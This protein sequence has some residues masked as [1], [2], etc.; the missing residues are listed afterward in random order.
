MCGCIWQMQ[1]SLSVVPMRNDRK[2]RIIPYPSGHVVVDG[3]GNKVVSCSTEQEAWEYVREV[4]Q[5]EA[6]LSPFENSEPVNEKL[7][8]T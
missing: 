3:A 4:L 6:E 5:G 1:A 7:F 8:T 2:Y